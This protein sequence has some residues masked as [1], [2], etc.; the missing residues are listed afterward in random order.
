MSEYSPYLGN[1]S[2]FIKLSQLEMDWIY[3]TRPMIHKLCVAKKIY[4]VAKNDSMPWNS[5]STS[6]GPN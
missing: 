5:E 1:G 4:C 2:Y 3:C 6:L